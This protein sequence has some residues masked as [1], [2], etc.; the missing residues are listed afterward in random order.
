MMTP[1]AVSWFPGQWLGGVQEARSRSWLKS[2]GIRRVITVAAEI[3]V[4]TLPRKEMPEIEWVFFQLED[5][6]RRADRGR[7]QDIM[8]GYLERVMKVMRDSVEKGIPTLVHCVMGA[9][10]APT[11]LVCFWIERYGWKAEEAIQQMRRFR[12]GSFQSDCHF[13]NL[14]LEWERRHFFNLVRR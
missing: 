10:R 9:Q 4:E 7:I 6:R 12:E 5:S 13:E 11:V 1:P 2:H 3:D 14:I 8:W